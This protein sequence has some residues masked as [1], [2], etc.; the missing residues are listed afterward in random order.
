MLYGRTLSNTLTFS[1]CQP[2]LLT[3]LAHWLVHWI[4]ANKLLDHPDGYGGWGNRLKT[5]L[6]HCLLCVWQNVWSHFVSLEA[7]SSSWLQADMKWKKRQFHAVFLEVISQALIISLEG[8]RRKLPLLLLLLFPLFSIRN[9]LERK[10]TGTKRQQGPRQKNKAADLIRLL[11]LS[12]TK[13]VLSLPPRREGTPVLEAGI[14]LI[15]CNQ[16]KR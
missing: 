13:W 4:Q 15:L 1:L 7:V 9:I 11:C 12:L 10:Q 8:R 14:L 6:V 3:T 5:R 2:T 16:E